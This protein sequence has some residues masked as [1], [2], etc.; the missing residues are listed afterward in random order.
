MKFNS[1]IE[2]GAPGPRGIPVKYQVI[3]I[4]V[5][6][7]K[8]AIEYGNIAE[9]IVPSPEFLSYFFA[10]TIMIGRYGI[11]GEMILVIESPTL[12]AT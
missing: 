3:S 4:I 8:K 10:K 2:V 12:Y 1:Y 6:Q 7:M 5:Q 11:S 9:M